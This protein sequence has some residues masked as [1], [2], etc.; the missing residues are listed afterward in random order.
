MDATKQVCRGEKKV[1]Y[2]YKPS[3]YLTKEKERKGQTHE[4]QQRIY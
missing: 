4:T 3:I 1:N 2:L